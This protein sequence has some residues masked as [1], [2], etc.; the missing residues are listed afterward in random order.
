MMSSLPFISPASHYPRTICWGSSRHT[1]WAFPFTWSQQTVSPSVVH[2]VSPSPFLDHV[3]ILGYLIAIL[4]F[5]F[6]DPSK[7]QICHTVGQ[8]LSSPGAPFVA[9]TFFWSFCE[10]VLCP[11]FLV[12]CWPNSLSPVPI[13]PTTLILRGIWKKRPGIWN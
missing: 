11:H 2:G 12:F 3:M 13:E 4:V 8:I 9:N 5:N 1:L 7:G 6:N 10:N